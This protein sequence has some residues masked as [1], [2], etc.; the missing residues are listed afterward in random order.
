[1]WPARL[2]TT[3][4][5][6]GY[7]GS[8]WKNYLRRTRTTIRQVEE[9]NFDKHASWT[10]VT[11]A[12]D[13]KI[14]PARYQDYVRAFPRGLGVFAMFFETLLQF[15]K[16]DQDRE[17][18]QDELTAFWYCNSA[19]PK[20][21]AAART[22]LKDRDRAIAAAFKPADIVL[23]GHSMGGIVI[24]GLLERFPDLHVSDIVVMASAASARETRRVLDRYYEDKAVQRRTVERQLALC[25]KACV[26]LRDLLPQPDPRFYS[27]M[28]H[29]MNDIEEENYFATVPLG[30]LLM[31]VDDLYE[32]PKTPEDKT[33]GFWPTA[34]AMRRMFGQAT[35]QHMVFRIF[36]RRDDEQHTVP[37]MHTHFNDTDKRFWCRS[38]WDGSPKEQ[39][40]GCY[41]Q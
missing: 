10:T 7:G 36:D 30:S 31:W 25:G 22:E 8:A 14:A 4:L 28:L 13:A 40:A 23:I 2:V 3:P 27:L 39:D 37:V 24:N 18:W 26:G 11:T 33:F 17:N 29:P 1:M 21:L 34:R 19:N 38:F 41:S 12:C 20:P 15:Q 35:Q 5:A 32:V 9:F 6:M 16:N